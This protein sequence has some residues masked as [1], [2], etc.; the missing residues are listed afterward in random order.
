MPWRTLLIAGIFLANLILSACASPTPVE[1]GQ[2]RSPLPTNVP[3]TGT[4]ATA[5][6][7]DIPPASTRTTEPI[8]QS[9]LPTATAGG[10]PT[11]TQ[12]SLAPGAT[13]AVGDVISVP[14]VPPAPT[15]SDPGIQKLVAQAKEDL[16][17]RLGIDGEQIELVAIEVVIWPDKGFGCPKPGIEYPQVPQDGLL[18][19]LRVGK[20]IYDYHWGSGKP[21]FLCE[22]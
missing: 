2:S 10:Q 7:T 1:P 11:A 9:P 16:V 8:V 21:P 17:Q 4:Q 5:L 6:P 14:K 3:G 13:L 18:I 20:R 12:I 19:Q 15:P 22:K